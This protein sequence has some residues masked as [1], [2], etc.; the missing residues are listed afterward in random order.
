MK[1]QSS[2]DA[3]AYVMALRERMGD[4]A[5]FGTERFTG[6]FLGRLICVTYHSGHEWNRRITNEKNCAVG[7]VENHENGCQVKFLHLKGLLCPPQLLMQTVI[8]FVFSVLI[9][10]LETA[11]LKLGL[12]TFG[13]VMAAF[14]ILVVPIYT[15]IESSTDRSIEGGKVLVA[16]LKDPTDPFAYLNYKK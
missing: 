1:V 15:L 3:E 8:C 5:A 16:T 12:I 11:S 13:I 9:C 2:L 14:L 7:V 6:F 4:R 10:L